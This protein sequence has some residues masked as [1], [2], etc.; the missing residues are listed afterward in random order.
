[1]TAATQIPV[2]CR[3]GL[4]PQVISDHLPNGRFRERTRPSSGHNAFTARMESW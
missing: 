1:M 2:F 4:F 3:F